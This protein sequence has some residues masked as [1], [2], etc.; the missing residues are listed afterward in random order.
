M[1]CVSQSKEEALSETGMTMFKDFKRLEAIESYFM[2]IKEGLGFHE[3]S[4]LTSKHIFFSG[5]RNTKVLNTKTI[6]HEA[7]ENGLLKCGI[8]RL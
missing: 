2:N 8:R 4:M 6:E 1:S 3:A 7:L 5:K